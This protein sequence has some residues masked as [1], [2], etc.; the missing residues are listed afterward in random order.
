MCSATLR[1]RGS[2]VPQSP[3]I[4][5]HASSAISYSAGRGLNEWLPRARRSSTAPATSITQLGSSGPKRT[6]C[7][8]DSI[9][10]INQLNGPRCAGASPGTPRSRSLPSKVLCIRLWIGSRDMNGTSAVFLPPEEASPGATG[11]SAARSWAT[12]SPLPANVSAA[13]AA[14]SCSSGASSCPRMA[15]T[16]LCISRRS[17]TCLIIGSLPSIGHGVARQHIPRRS[18]RVSEK[19]DDQHE[20][21][22]RCKAW[23]R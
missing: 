10:W 7:R 22:H 5:T 20:R 23:A 6:G 4:T 21:N 17:T 12:G 9:R 11:G 1:A 16:Y 13:R 19:R 3:T 2:P 14:A 8:I 18:G 15:S